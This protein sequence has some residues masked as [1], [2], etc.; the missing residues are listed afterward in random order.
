MIRIILGIACSLWFVIILACVLFWFQN[1]H[2]WFHSSSFWW[3]KS[4]SLISS[5]HLSSHLHHLDPNSRSHPRIESSP[6]KNLLPPS[7]SF[8]LVLFSLSL[9]FVWFALSQ[10]WLCNPPQKVTIS[11]FYSIN[12]MI[13]ESEEEDEEKM[14]SFFDNSRFWNSLVLAPDH[15]WRKKKKEDHPQRDQDN[16]PSCQK[17]QNGAHLVSVMPRKVV[18]LIGRKIM[19]SAGSPPHDPGKAPAPRGSPQWVWLPWWR[20][21]ENHDYFWGKM[22]FLGR[23]S[24]VS[25]HRDSLACIF[26]I[27]WNFRLRWWWINVTSWFARVGWPEESTGAS[28]SVPSFPGIGK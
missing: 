23:D 3:W 6:R 5:N 24:S 25:G 20:W 19:D 9:F 18:F 15:D 1:S 26:L 22:V 11:S 21:Q 8:R 2:D 7:F 28:P 4:S 12:I 10:S 27:F 17:G 16:V 14:S 13:I